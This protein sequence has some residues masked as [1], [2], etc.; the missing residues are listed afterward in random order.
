MIIKTKNI[1]WLLLQHQ[2]F[3]CWENTFEWQ[4]QEGIV[5]LEKKTLIKGFGMLASSFSNDSHLIP[6]ADNDTFNNCNINIGI[7]QGKT[8]FLSCVTL[9]KIQIGCAREEY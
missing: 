9:K 1:Q 6:S 5:Y 2:F 3:S 7:L 4:S 8:S